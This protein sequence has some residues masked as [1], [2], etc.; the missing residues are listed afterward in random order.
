MGNVSM[1]QQ[2]GAACWDGLRPCEGVEAKREH[3]VAQGDE[4][5]PADRGGE[6]AGG[7]RPKVTQQSKTER[8]GRLGWT[9]EGMKEFE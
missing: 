4:P 1:W 5:A 2:K 7:N 9:G 6:A 3:V 8:G